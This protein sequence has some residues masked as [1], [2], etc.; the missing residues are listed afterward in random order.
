M[1]LSQ[2]SLY[3]T[4]ISDLNLVI[5][6]LLTLFESQHILLSVLA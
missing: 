1:V 2:D 3:H 6:L 5:F 4:L